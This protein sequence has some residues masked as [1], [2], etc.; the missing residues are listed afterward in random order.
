MCGTLTE[1]GTLIDCGNLTESGTL[2]HC[3][4]LTEWC[5]LTDCG[6]LIDCCTL[7][8]C[9]TLIDWCTLTECGT[10][11]KCYSR[12]DLSRVYRHYSFFSPI[13][14]VLCSLPNLIE[15]SLLNNMILIDFISAI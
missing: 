10:L 4:T 1:S 5:T 12:I 3:G 14:S 9:G 8:D 13:L 7:T 11:T 6:T 15:E 2:T